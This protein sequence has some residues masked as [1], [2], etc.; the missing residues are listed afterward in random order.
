[1]I[2]LLMY[3]VRLKLFSVHVMVKVALPR[4]HSHSSSLLLDEYTTLWGE[5]E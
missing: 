3:F 2:I 4:S 1:M 5:P